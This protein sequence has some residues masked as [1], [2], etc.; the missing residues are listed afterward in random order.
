[1]G[2]LVWLG[3]GE[4]DEF[5]WIKGWR[6]II[7]WAYEGMGIFFFFASLA[8]WVSFM[9]DMMVGCMD[10]RFSFQLL[11][12]GGQSFIRELIEIGYGHAWVEFLQHFY[13][14]ERNKRGSQF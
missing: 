10:Y 14:V 4:G 7:L 1:M 12:S 9:E 3:G 2:E 11:G 13:G 6:G 5:A 8:G